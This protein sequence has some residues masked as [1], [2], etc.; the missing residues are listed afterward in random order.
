[1]EDVRVLF[2]YLVKFFVN[3]DN[4]FFNQGQGLLMGFVDEVNLDH[5]FCVGM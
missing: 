2:D 4:L 3:S 5:L 1:M